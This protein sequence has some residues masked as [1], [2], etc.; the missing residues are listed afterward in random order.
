MKLDGL[1]NLLDVTADALA[2]AWDESK[3]KA[4]AHL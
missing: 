4:A 2:A 1:L 3:K